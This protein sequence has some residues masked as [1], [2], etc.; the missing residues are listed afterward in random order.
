MVGTRVIVIAAGDGTR[1]N[2][3]RDTP[4]HLVTIEKEILLQRKVE[5]LKRDLHIG[6]DYSAISSFRSV[7]K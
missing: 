1:W 7:D 6:L 3:Y 2:N 4:K 5:V